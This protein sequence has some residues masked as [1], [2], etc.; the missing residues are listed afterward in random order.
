MQTQRLKQT[1]F[2]NSFYA[3][4]RKYC[5][6]PVSLLLACW[7]I[8]FFLFCCYFF[9]NSIGL[10]CALGA[11]EMRPFIEAVG[12]CTTAYVLCYPNAGNMSFPLA[13]S[14]SCSLCLETG[15]MSCYATIHFRSS[16]HLWRLWWNTRDDCRTIKGVFAKGNIV[17]I[18]AA[19]LWSPWQHLKTKFKIS[20]FIFIFWIYFFL[21]YW[22]VK[23]FIQQYLC[24]ITSNEL[25]ICIIL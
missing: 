1:H 19:S 11:T 2:V 7:L 10:N 22:S 8:L 17:L 25:Q 12:L 14:F 13:Y 23:V 21:C 5:S 4:F 15:F 3:T 9:L 20:I 18:C 6:N 24:I 16:K